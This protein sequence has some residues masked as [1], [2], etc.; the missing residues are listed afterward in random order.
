MGKYS[1][2]NLRGN[3]KEED[4]GH[5]K[6]ANYELMLLPSFIKS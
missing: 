2:K 5:E 4:E 6:K 3:W 1:K